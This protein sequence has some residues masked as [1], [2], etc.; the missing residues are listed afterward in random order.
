MFRLRIP[1]IPCPV[2]IFGMLKRSSCI[3]ALG[4][5]EGKKAD[6]RCSILVVYFFPSASKGVRHDGRLRCFLWDFLSFVAVV[7]FQWLLHCLCQTF[8][9]C[10]GLIRSIDF[11]SPKADGLYKGPCLLLAALITMSRSCSVISVGA[12]HP[13]VCMAS[14]LDSVNQSSFGR[15]HLFTWKILGIFEPNSNKTCRS[16]GCC[17]EIQKCWPELT[18]QGAMF[19]KLPMVKRIC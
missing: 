8:L 15:P 18:S 2:V 5:W 11:V 10:R 14:F 3:S 4:I 16:G 17:R 12:S 6:S 9:H 19:K 1:P 7:F 13:T